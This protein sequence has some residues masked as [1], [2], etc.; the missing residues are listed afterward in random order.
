MSAEFSLKLFNHIIR[1]LHSQFFEDLRTLCQMN[2]LN[3]SLDTS[4]GHLKI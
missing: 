2:S 3:L 4:P 1:I